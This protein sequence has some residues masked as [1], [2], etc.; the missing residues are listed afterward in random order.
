MP[1]KVLIVT[2]G[3]ILSAAVA[4]AREASETIKALESTGLKTGETMEDRTRSI[5]LQAARISRAWDL[6][7]AIASH[8]ADEML[9]PD[10]VADPN[11]RGVPGEVN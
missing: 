11:H 10:D 2:E 9:S 6:I 1:M 7:D 3:E 5:A 4:E 8:R